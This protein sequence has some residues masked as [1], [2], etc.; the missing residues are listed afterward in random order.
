M[1]INVRKLTAGQL[2]LLEGGGTGWSQ[3]CFNII[4]NLKKL[5]LHFKQKNNG[6][7]LVPVRVCPMIQEVFFGAKINPPF[8]TKNWWWTANVCSY[9]CKVGLWCC[10]Q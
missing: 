1:N 7:N 3:G 5:I 9:D 10:S 6:P 2:I 8:E 4:R